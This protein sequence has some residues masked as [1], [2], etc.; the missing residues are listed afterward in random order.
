MKI[1]IDA[2]S[3]EHPGGWVV[4][5]QFLLQMGQGYLLAIEKPGT[6]VED[7]YTSIKIPAAGKY[8]LWARCKNWL[9]EYSPGQ[10]TVSIGNQAGAHTLGCM[11]TENWVWEIAGDFDLEAG[12][13]RLTMRDLT[14]YYARCAA[15]ILTDDINFTPPQPV[16]RLQALRAALLGLPMEIQNGDAYDVIVAGGGPGGIPAAISA[17]RAGCKTLLIHSRPVLGGNSST[18]AG[19]GYDG[20]SSRQPHAREG[21]IAEE[22]RRIRDHFDCSWE[23][24]VN[25]LIEG[26]DNLT[27]LK[28]MAVVDAETEAN[29]RAEVG[30]GAGANVRA[31]AGAGAGTGANG[32]AIIKSVVAQNVLSLVKTRYFGRMFID[33]TGDG[34]LG[35]FAGA[36]YRIGREAAWEYNETLAPECA[37]NVTMSGCLMGRGCGTSF[38][39]IDTG[40]PV[41]FERPAWLYRFPPGREWNRYVTGVHGHWWIEHPGDVDDL[42]DAEKARD[43]L[44]RIALSFFGWLKYD[45]DEKERA[46]NYDVALMPITNAKRENRRFIGDY[47]LSEGDCVSGKSFPDTIGHTGWTIDVHHPLGVFS[48]AEGPFHANMH[49]PM[50]HLPY[51]CLYSKNIDNLLFAGRN[52]SVTHVA[53]GTVRVQNSIAVAAQAAG[54][55]SAIAI[56]RDTTPRGVYENHLSEL[57]QTLLRNDQFIPGIANE[58][59]LDLARDAVAEA[60]SVSAGEI[61]NDSQGIPGEWKFLDCR[62]AGMLPRENDDEI[63]SIWIYMRNTGASSTPVTARVRKERDPGLFWNEEDIAESTVVLASGFEG[64]V[65]LPVNRRVEERYIWVWLEKLSP[66]DGALVAWRGMD[67]SPL[68][69]F[70]ASESDNGFSVDGRWGM[71]M[72]LQPP[73]ETLADT[74]PAQITNG[75]GRIVSPD[76]YM[77]VSGALPA[78]ITLRWENPQK[79]SEALLTFDTDMNNPPMTFPRFPVHPNC[80]TEFTLSGMDHTGN[81]IVLKKITNNFQRR[82]KIFFDAIELLQLKLEITAT[83]GAPQARLIEIR[84]Y[85]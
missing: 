29:G 13:T 64:W 39:A 28:N 27:I 82:V 62:R 41:N 81:W 55:A 43:E 35:F 40:A 7:A 79:I 18:E 33:C 38:K 11:P 68:D 54:T 6:P 84:C 78:W 30:S 17:A 85:S 1:W 70:S 5:T 8:R 63:G 36:D 32:G 46:V 73:C 52:I 48:G 74:S 44:V 58:D 22:L 59:S 23:E 37:D 26:Q 9:R 31:E 16:E 80:A 56:K 12:E 76:R 47:V 60:S 15:F 67:M 57:Q 51:R 24:A 34:W 61:F 53:L 25:R 65:E 50:V 45:W 77:W 83:G 66:S 49:I 75:Y 72:R 14:G 71:M 20:A 2:I 69:W 3:F 21:G 42:F 10:F 19:V 4:D